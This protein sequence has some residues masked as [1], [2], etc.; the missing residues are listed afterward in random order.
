MVRTLAEVLRL[1]YSR[2]NTRLCLDP[3]RSDAGVCQELAAGVETY[4]RIPK[5]SLHASIGGSRGPALPHG[6]RAGFLVCRPAI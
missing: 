5:F 4:G 2:R 3:R 1:R 6:T